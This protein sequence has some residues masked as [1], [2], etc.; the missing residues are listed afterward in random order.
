MI[1]E[2][3]KNEAEVRLKKV[4]GQIRGISKMVT[5]E[6]YCIDIIHQISAA[7]KAPDKVAK[8]IMKRHIE[9]CVQE[10]IR[11]GDSDQKVDELIKTVFKLSDRH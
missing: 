8:I 10:A 1:D 6:K 7:E 2:T 4:E 9:S 5:D 3:T 11:S